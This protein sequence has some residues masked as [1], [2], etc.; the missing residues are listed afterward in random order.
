MATKRDYYEI[1]G[2]SRNASVEEI[3]KSYRKLALQYHPDRNPGNKESEEK[4]KEA[5]EAYAVLTDSEKRAQYDQFGHSLGG[6]GF[7]GF[8]GFEN[9]F[10]GFGDV[11]GDIFEDFFGVGSGGSRGGR[12]SRPRRGSDLEM[13]LELELK[14]VLKGREEALK[15][16]RRETCGSC[17]GSGAAPG[18]KKTTCADC[19]GHG[20]VRVTQGFFTMRR[21][22]P[23][24][25][26][27]GEKIDKLCAQCGGEGRSEQIRKINL[28]IPAGV[29]T[30]ARLKISGEGEAGERGGP[31]GD[32]YIYIEIK[33]H[34]QFER[35]ESDLFCEMLIPY[36]VAVLGGEITVPTLESETTLKIPAGTASGKIL[37]IKGE[38]LP[39]LRAPAERGDEYVRVEIEVPKKIT[40]AERK[41]LQEYAKSRGEKAQW[42]KKN[43]FEQLKDSL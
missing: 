30:G 39:H 42:R 19:G 23:R 29:D 3:K 17:Q 31:R 11:F 1:L 35:R 9:A 14:D 21:S 43:L 22:C 37:K 5:A 2:V 6:R 26:G 18:A 38:G 32:L 20:E 8:E 7:Q 25:G 13:K 16:P 4:F 12:R 28:K 27:A 15:I 41:L 24:C 10:Q 40:D 36:T 34:P 33:N